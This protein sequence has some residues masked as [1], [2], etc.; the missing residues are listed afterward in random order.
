MTVESDHFPVYDLSITLRVSWQA[1]SLSNAGDNGSNRLLPRR[2]LLADGTETDALSGNIL[3]HHHA[4]LMAEYLEAAGSPLCPACQA[5]DAR[6]A[7]ALIDRPEYQNISVERILNEC[8]LCDTHG[9]LVTAKN[10]ASDGS[11]EARL[12]QNKHTIIDFAYALGLP[13]QH[14]ET[15]QLHTR[16]GGSKEEGQML[17]KISSRSGV[18]ALCIR[19]HCARIGVDTEQ[20]QLVVEDEQERVKRYRAALRALRDTF[21]SPEGAHTATM[22]PHLT[23]L[24][25][26][27]VICRKAGRAPVY[28]ALADDFLARLQAMQGEE[29]QIYPF[30][31]IDGFYR[32]LTHLGAASEPALPPGSQDSSTQM[33]KLQEHGERT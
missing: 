13:D 12:R 2:Q 4:V 1:H 24:S 18:Y 11:T 19:Y 33:G 8:A 3:K 15:L 6:R 29:C 31:A 25:G 23:G 28:S 22:L 9:F 17:M 10:A 30:E 26:A 27:I 32:H 20:W 16:S 5:R 21:T 14:K 7:A